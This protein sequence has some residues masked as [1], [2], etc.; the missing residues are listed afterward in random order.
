MADCVVNKKDAFVCTDL[1]EQVIALS[2]ELLQM[3]I[4][5]EARFI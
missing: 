3:F 4:L 2:D 5:T 1:A